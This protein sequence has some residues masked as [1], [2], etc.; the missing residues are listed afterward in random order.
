MLHYDTVT[1]KFYYPV[2][3]GV[4]R[5]VPIVMRPITRNVVVGPWG[6]FYTVENPGGD[7]HQVIPIPTV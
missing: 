3:P 4:Y 5:P 2:R 7:T 6:A 1:N